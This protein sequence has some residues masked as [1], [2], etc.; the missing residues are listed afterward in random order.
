LRATLERHACVFG[1]HNHINISIDSEKSL[2][3]PSSRI[4]G[5]LEH[6]EELSATMPTNVLVPPRASA[7]FKIP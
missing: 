4:A 3:H 1:F 6:F 5:G 2:S 7:T